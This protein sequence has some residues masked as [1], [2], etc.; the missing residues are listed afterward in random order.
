VTRTR[1]CHWK[2]EVRL[3]GYLPFTQDIDVPAAM[4]A[5]T[6]T[7][8]DVRIDL[9][10]GA[11]VGGTVRDARGQRAPNAHVVV[12][13][14]TSSAEGDADAQGEFRIHDAPTGDVVVEATR[15]DATGS[16]HVTVRAGDEVLGLAVEI[17]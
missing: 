4:R 17:R 1:R 10:R 2:L 14:A 6:T 3:P 11:L 16:T 12:K 5:G 13:S 9:A 15:G 8:R 7:V